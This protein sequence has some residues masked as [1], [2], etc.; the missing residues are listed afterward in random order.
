[1]R[2]FVLIALVAA[3]GCVEHREG[4][5]GAQSLRV[6][7]IAPADPGSFENRLPLTARDVTIQ[8]SAIGPDGLVDATFAGTVDVRAQFLGSLTPGLDQ[9]PLTTVQLTAGMSAPTMITLPAEVFGQTLVWVED[10]DGDDATYATGTSPVLWFRDPLISDIQRPADEMALDALVS[11][12]LEDRQI[13]VTASRYNDPTICPTEDCGRLI[14]TSIYAQG[15]T[16]SDVQCGPG[17]APPCVTDDYDHILVFSFN[18]PRDENGCELFV[19]QVIDGFAGAVT[20]FLG[21]TEIGFPQTFVAATDPLP[22]TT[23]RRCAANGDVQDFI[24]RGVVVPAALPPPTPVIATGPG[25]W[26]GAGVIEFERHEAGLVS[27]DSAILEAGFP[28]AC[29]LDDEWETFQQWELDVG[30]GCKSPVSVITAGV[31]TSWV[32]EDHVG[33]QLTRVVGSLRPVN[34][35]GFNVWILFPRSTDDLVP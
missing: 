15:Y 18:R 9:N 6:D 20:E 24:D 3:S 16:V 23:D 27:V 5:Q 2:A 11:S 14:V 30:L 35:E 29:P 21:L 32:P 33:M 22:G 17:G 25:S 19:G 13:A 34:G 4:V 28:I 1:M 31:V 7:L 10:G 8:V 26:F 12:P